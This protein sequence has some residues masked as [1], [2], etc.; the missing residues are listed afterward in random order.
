MKLKGNLYRLVDDGEALTEVPAPIEDEAP[1]PSP[2]PS[3]VQPVIAISPYDVPRTTRR[4]SAGLVSADAELVLWLVD[5][6]ATV[7][8]IVTKSPMHEE[9]TLTALRELYWAAVIAFD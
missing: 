2:R 8:E 9:D 4:E 1:A 7:L 3:H 5:G 6:T